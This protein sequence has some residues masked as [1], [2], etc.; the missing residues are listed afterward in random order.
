MTESFQLNPA[1]APRDTVA[2]Y[3]EGVKCRFVSVQMLTEEGGIP[4]IVITVPATPELRHV[5]PRTRVHLIAVEPAPPHNVVVM[6]EFE[7]T[8]RGFDKG[9]DSRNLT[10]TAVH[11]TS[12]LDQYEI[13]TLDVTAAI[14]ALGGAGSLTGTQVTAP[15]TGNI[16]ELINTEQLTSELRE[17]ASSVNADTALA[18][19]S[20]AKTP[21]RAPNATQLTVRDVVL[22][23]FLLYR[24]IFQ[25]S[26]ISDTY[27]SVA[28]DMHQLIARFQFPDPELIDWS[29]VYSKL[30]AQLLVQ[31]PQ[32]A[33]G[34][35]TFFDVIRGICQFFLHGVHVI[36]NAESVTKQIQI[37]PLTHFNAVPHLSLI[38]I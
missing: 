23:T 33:G 17:F 29:D 9:D 15:L 3:I 18:A 11:V 27:T 31:G 12:H 2:L 8:E 5:G 28:V 10:F 4:Y 6:G 34:S 19:S 37:K 16:L 35:Q 20:A 25:N 21:N 30:M 1:F 7:I 26:R 32:Q 22:G 24:K 14:Q 38:H 13:T 36:P